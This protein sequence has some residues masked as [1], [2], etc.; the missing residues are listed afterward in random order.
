M[1]SNE[2]K[3]NPLGHCGM[4]VSQLSLGGWTTYGSS[5]TDQITIGA[6]L[7]TAFDS[8]I[9]YFDIA[10]VYE[11]GECEKAMGKILREFPRHELVI[12]SKVFFPMSND[13]ND[14]GLSRKHILES[15]DKTLKRIGTDYLDLYFCHRF[16]ENTPL[17]ETVRAMDHLVN[18]GKVLYWGTSEWTGDQIREANAICRQRNFY[19]PQAEQPRY[20]LLYRHKIE[21]DVRSALEECGMGMVVFSPLGSGILT[22]KYDDGVPSD[23][24]LAK[25]DWLRER[26][27][28]E[29]YLQKVRRMKTIAD[30]LG[31]TRAQLAL[32]WAAAQ[33]GVSSVITGAT[34][35]GQVKE[36]LQS[37]Q[38]EITSEIQ[39]QLNEIFPPQIRD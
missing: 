10:D 35:T 2:M 32:A 17:E 19:R 38:I 28:R 30:E 5:V 8:G 31:C 27:L 13:V 37:L 29:D 12:A 11:C 3:Y 24:R 14:R 34:R 20:S 33:P 4:K 22:G 9:N 18:Q 7:R 21:T 39:A 26:E 16:D 1:P 6:I 15:I 36:N 25:I 23:S